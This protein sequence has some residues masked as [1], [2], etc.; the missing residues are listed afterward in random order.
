MK[1]KNLRVFCMAFF[2]EFDGEWQGKWDR[3]KSWFQRFS[4][5]ITNEESLVT[6]SGRNIL[7]NECN[8]KDGYADSQAESFAANHDEL[9][10]KQRLKQNYRLKIK[11]YKK[12]QLDEVE[13]I[14]KKYR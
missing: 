4:H 8:S 6:T 12:V 10:E 14:L 11:I 13:K 3:Y 5:Q 1:K 7:G 9:K 2:L